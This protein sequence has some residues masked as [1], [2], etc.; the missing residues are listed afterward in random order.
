M[1]IYIILE[2][3]LADVKLPQLPLL[4]LLKI[5]G[6][7]SCAGAAAAALLSSSDG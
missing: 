7:K 5:H 4:L 1:L 2:L 3:L 6:H